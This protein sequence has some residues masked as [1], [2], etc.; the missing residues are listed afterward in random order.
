MM[1]L[2]KALMLSV[3]GLMFMSGGSLA[4]I[5]NLTSFNSPGAVT[6]VH[7]PYTHTSHPEETLLSSAFYPLPENS[8][9]VREGFKPTL[10][11]PK[12]LGRVEK[13]QGDKIKLAA[14]CFVTDTSA[15]SGNEFAGNN[16]DDTGHGA[17]GGPGDG[18]DYDLDNEER[19]RQEGYTLSSC[20]P[21]ETPAT[22]CPYDNSIFAECTCPTGYTTCESPYFGVGEA[23]GNK[24]ASCECNPC[25]GYDYTSVPEGYVQE[26]ESCLGCDG[27]EHYKIKPNPC[28]GFLDCGSMGGETGANSCLSGSVTKY[29]N[30]KPCPNLGTLS[31]CPAGYSCTF[32][33]CSGLSYKSGCSPN[34]TYFC[35][36]PQTDCRALGYTETSCSGSA[37]KCPYNST[38]LF[39]L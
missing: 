10:S 32:E 19:C 16:A 17:P 33:E 7:T 31:S 20:L 37:L 18:D 15:C 36:Q 1:K 27:Q 4:S 5:H 14:T 25:T 22:P 39:C 24:Y 34:Y 11:L 21:G 8:G 9:R 35:T 2:S 38:L 3:S 29:D 23:C 6:F 12:S 26:G 13:R 28:D 30:C